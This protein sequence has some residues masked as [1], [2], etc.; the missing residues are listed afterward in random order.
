MRRLSS[1]WL[2]GQEIRKNRGGL[3]RVITGPALGEVIEKMAATVMV[4]KNEHETTLGAAPDSGR[5]ATCKTKLAVK[6]VGDDNEDEDTMTAAEESERG[7]MTKS[8]DLDEVAKQVEQRLTRKRTG[9]M[10]DGRPIYEQKQK[11]R[12][13]IDS[14]RGPVVRD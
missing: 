4:C 2:E 14:P 12:A 7:V 8:I 11:S 3:G 13:Q 1:T 6:D 10:L 5:C 9:G